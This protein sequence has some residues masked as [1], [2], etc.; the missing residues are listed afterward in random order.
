MA[1][2]KARATAQTTTP[3]T[4]QGQQAKTAAPV[5]PTPPALAAG[6]VALPSYQTTPRQLGLAPAQGYPQGSQPIVVLPLTA[7][8][9]ALYQKYH[10][11]LAAACGG[12]GVAQPLNVVLANMVAAGVANPRRALRRA[13]RAWLV[14]WQ[15]VA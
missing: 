10:A 6:F 5:A 9:S 7:G 11:Q 1:N 12:V 4:K 15:P 3:A 13:C 8:Q 2:T 14:G